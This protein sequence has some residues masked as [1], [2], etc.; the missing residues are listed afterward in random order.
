MFGNL[1]R[2]RRR[3]LA[4]RQ[5]TSPGPSVAPFLE[6]FVDTAAAAFVAP[7]AAASLIHAREQ[8]VKAGHELPTGC[9]PRDEG[10][11]RFALD[12]PGVLECCD[13]QNDPRFAAL[14]GV[15]GEPHIRYYIGAP[16]RLSNGIDVGALCV[17]DTVLR[18]PA[19][20]DKKAY[21]LGLARQAAMALE[22][23]LDLW[24]HAA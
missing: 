24:G 22:H 15:V 7:M 1:F 23:R 11:C 4:I 21:L 13:P 18:Q 6:R 10:F 19:S 3:T 2:E 8:T 9:L 16:L 12:R 14:P 17:A 20:H 5:M